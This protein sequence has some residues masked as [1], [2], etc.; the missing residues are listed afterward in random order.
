MS[1]D[2]VSAEIL[3]DIASYLDIPS[4]LSF[5]QVDRHVNDAFKK[6]KR[7]WTLVTKYIGLEAKK[8]DSVDDIKA[9]FIKWKSGTI[10]EI[11]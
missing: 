5:I 1:L 7:F 6:N 11:I 9:R 4:A 8:S 10:Q 3:E 2:S